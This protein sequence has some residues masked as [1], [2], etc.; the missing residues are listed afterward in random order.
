ML[1]HCSP[2]CY[3][4]HLN[5]VYRKTRMITKF[6]CRAALV[7]FGFYWRRKGTEADKSEIT[8]MTI[9]PHSS[10]CDTIIMLII[11]E[12]PYA[13]SRVENLSIPII[14]SRSLYSLCIVVIV[15]SSHTHVGNRCDCVYANIIGVQTCLLVYCALWHIHLTCIH[16]YSHVFTCIHAMP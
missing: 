12:L 9:A 14:G 7:S 3:G 8:A 15:S 1:L 16:M 11:D 4:V 13:I 2:L 6:F 5:S 10:F